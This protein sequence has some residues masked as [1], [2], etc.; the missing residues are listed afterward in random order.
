MIVNTCFNATDPNVGFALSSDHS[1]QKCYMADTGLL[2]TQTFMD[3]AFTENELYRAIL[4]DKLSINE[5][6]IMENVVAQMLRANDHKLYFYSRTDA[7]NRKNDMKIDFLIAE[8]KMIASIEV[9]SNH[10]VSHSSLD[11]FRDKFSSKIGNSYILYSKVVTLKD[12]I[13]HLPFYMVVFL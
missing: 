10:Y 9:K 4:F 5:G 3:K 7:A 11:K 1:T 6:M 13:I 8:G 12:G 2:V